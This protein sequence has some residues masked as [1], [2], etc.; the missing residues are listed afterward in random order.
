MLIKKITSSDNKADTN[1]DT[2][3]TPTLNNNK[4]QRRK[5]EIDAKPYR[6][7][8]IPPQHTKL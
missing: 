3:T 7:A 5:L 1:S 2:K 6:I 8:F 4:T